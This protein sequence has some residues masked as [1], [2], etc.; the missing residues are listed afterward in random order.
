MF[1]ENSEPSVSRGK[2][3]T[4]NIPRPVKLAKSA[5]DKMTNHVSSD[6]RQ[7]YYCGNCHR[8]SLSFFNK[9]N[10]IEKNFIFNGL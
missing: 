3:F 2:R 8:A 4:S 1:K 5:T 10:R 6:S 7:V 9:S